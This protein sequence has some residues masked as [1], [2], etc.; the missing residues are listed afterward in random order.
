MLIIKDLFVEIA[1]SRQK[2]IVFG[3]NP[4][5]CGGLGLKNL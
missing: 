2:I 5:L 4:Y 3:K 1:K